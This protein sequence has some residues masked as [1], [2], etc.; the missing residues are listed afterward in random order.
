MPLRLRMGQTLRNEGKV[1]A[2]NEQ[3]APDENMEEIDEDLSDVRGVSELED[4]MRDGEDICED[5]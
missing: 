4:Y 5:K 1:S 2:D 3:P